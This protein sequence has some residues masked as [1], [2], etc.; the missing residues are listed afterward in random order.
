VKVSEPS[1]IL[2]LSNRHILLG[3]PVLISRFPT[4]KEEAV[5][6]GATPALPER[7]A[8]KII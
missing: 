1:Y 5:L 8:M 6:L 3:K 7:Q 4:Q 2:D